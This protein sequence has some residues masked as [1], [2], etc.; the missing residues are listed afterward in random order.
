MATSACPTGGLRISV[1][2][3]GA[4]A[5]TGY[6]LIRFE[7]VSSTAC[8]LFGY[9]GVSFLDRHGRQVGQPAARAN[10]NGLPIR[11]A[12]LNPGGFAHALVAMPNP[13]NFQ[14][15]PSPSQNNCAPASYSAVR[16]YP[17]NQRQA[18]VVPDQGT[19]CT[20]TAGASV[21]PVRPGKEPGVNG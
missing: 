9:P 18:L 14:T 13:Y 1:V 20:T 16:V 21:N 10:F 8:N 12:V 19:I 11:A 3:D 2:P 6:E 15:G 5:G 4:A 17:P 7:N